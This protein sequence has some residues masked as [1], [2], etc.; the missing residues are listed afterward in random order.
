MKHLPQTKLIAA[1]YLDAYAFQHGLERPLTPE[2]V[3]QA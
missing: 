3:R 1:L 2:Q